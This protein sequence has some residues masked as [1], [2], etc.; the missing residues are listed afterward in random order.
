VVDVERAA[1]LYRDG[2][3]AR[4]IAR[5]LGTSRTAVYTALRAHGVVMRPRGTRGA[6]PSNHERGT[7]TPET[8]QQ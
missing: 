3:S 5:L 7:P 6:D 1:R 2:A 4:G 8:S